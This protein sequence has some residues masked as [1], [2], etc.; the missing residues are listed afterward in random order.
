VF[1]L[2]GAEMIKEKQSG[3]VLRNLL[4]LPTWIENNENVFENK[5]Q[6]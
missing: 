2:G 4:F 6:N 5:V 1:D 3:M